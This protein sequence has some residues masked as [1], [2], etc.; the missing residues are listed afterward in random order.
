MKIDQSK[1]ARQKK[2]ISLW[3]AAN[4]QGT[5]EAAT[6]FGKSFI[7]ALVI[8]ALNASKSDA[9]ICI[10]VPSDYLRNK[11]RKDVETHGLKNVQVDTINMWVKEDRVDCDL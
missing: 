8:M 3:N 11:W 7:G 10:C 1:L 5:I 4:K 9:K 2:G 6:G